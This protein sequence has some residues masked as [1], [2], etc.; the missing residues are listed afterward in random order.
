MNRVEFS[1]VLSIFIFLILSMLGVVFEDNAFWTSF[2]FLVMNVIFV[3]YDFFV[4]A[5]CVDKNKKK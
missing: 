3:A 2:V 5:N 4:H 1:V